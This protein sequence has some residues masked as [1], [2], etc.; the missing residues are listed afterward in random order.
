ME[1]IEKN[2]IKKSKKRG[3]TGLTGGLLKS[4]THEEYGVREQNEKHKS[5]KTLTEE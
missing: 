1:G 5:S 2:R 4:V 3:Q